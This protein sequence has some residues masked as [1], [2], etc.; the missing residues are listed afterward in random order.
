[1][2]VKVEPSGKPEKLRQY[3]GKVFD[4]VERSEEQLKVQ[5]EEPERLSRIPGVE[6]YSYGGE[7]YDGLGGSVIEEK[8]LSKLENREDAVKIFL[9]TLAGYHVDVIDSDHE[10]DLKALRRYNPGIKNLKGEGWEDFRDSNEKSVNG[11]LE[12]RDQLELDMPDEDKI[13]DIYRE[14][15]T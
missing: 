8:S 11:K 2:E 9:A 3:L 5:T 10:W 6:S 15:L 13:V 7:N 4:S 1:M 12:G 14:Y